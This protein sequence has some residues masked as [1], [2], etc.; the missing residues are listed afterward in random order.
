MAVFFGDFVFVFVFVCFLFFLFFFF[1]LEC[2][3]TVLCLALFIVNCYLL[4]VICYLFQYVQLYDVLKE[5]FNDIFEKIIIKHKQLGSIVQLPSHS[6]SDI[7]QSRIA[8]KLDKILESNNDNLEIQCLEIIHC[9]Q[10]IYDKYIDPQNAQF[11]INISYQTRKVLTTIFN[12]S[13]YKKAHAQQQQQ[14][15]QQQDGSG[16]ASKIKKM[17]SNDHDTNVSDKEAQKSMVDDDNIVKKRRKTTSDIASDYQKCW[18]TEQWQTKMKQF[19]QEK[20]LNENENDSEND[21]NNNDK[22]KKDI[23]EWLIEFLL[24]EMQVAFREIS[25]LMNDSFYRF[26]GTPQAAKFFTT[27]TSPIASKHSLL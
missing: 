20:A 14:R 13:F 7:P 27:N 19:N 16:I 15:Q 5:H 11:N 17:T 10:I 12:V 22:M 21:N 26:K 24:V 8:Y 3:V 6:D 9:F 25:S 18:I 1:E 2:N 4:F 23:L